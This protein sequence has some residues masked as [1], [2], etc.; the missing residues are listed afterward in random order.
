MRRSFL[1][2]EEEHMANPFV[3]VELQTNDLA[4]AKS[5]YSKLFD[6]KLE[7]VP[8]PGTGGTYTMIGVGEG[9]GGGMLKSMALA[10][11][12][13]QWLAYV[14]VGDVASSTRKAREL[15]A[16]VVLDKTEVGEFGWM[17]ILTD[18]TGATFALWQAKQPQRSQ[19]K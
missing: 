14:G 6:W 18:P 8:M 4:K 7:D 12:P 10:G 15:G 19:K 11:A 17:S 9:T 13:P 1:R 5:F 16:K 2:L 3:H